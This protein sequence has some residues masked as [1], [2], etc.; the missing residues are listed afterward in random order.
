MRQ[1]LFKYV[2]GATMTALLVLGTGAAQAT[3]V[4][5]ATSTLGGSVI[6]FEGFAENTFIDTQFAGVTFGQDDGGR[7]IIDNSP[8]KFGFTSNSGDGVLT[9]SRDGGAPFETVAGLEMVFGPLASAVEFFFSDTAPLGD[10]VV[11]VFGTGG[12]LESL[13]IPLGDVLGGQFILITRGSADVLRVAIDGDVSNDAYA[14][15]DVRFTAVPE[16]TTLLL[17]GLGLVGLGFRRRNI[18]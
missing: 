7:P 12:L 15:D 11:D 1:P 17:L 16:P 9:G 3:I 5:N 4:V 18:H 6:D 2:A 8:F 10:Y 13:T 14:I